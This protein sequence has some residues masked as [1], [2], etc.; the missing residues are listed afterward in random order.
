M[1]AV[2]VLFSDSQQA[3]AAREALQGTRFGMGAQDIVTVE[4]PEDYDRI[5]PLRHSRAVLGAVLGATWVGL[6]VGIVLVGLAIS[7]AVDLTLTSTWLP[8]VLGVMYGAVIGMLAG[9][10]APAP[11]AL[12]MRRALEVG[13]PVVHARFR[14]PNAAAFARSFLSSY[15]GAEYALVT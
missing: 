3:S 9:S 7:P 15:P 5:A 6:I 14:E 4:R 13:H 10:R 12:H 8:L 11:G 1:Y 2:E